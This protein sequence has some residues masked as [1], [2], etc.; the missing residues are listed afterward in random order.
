MHSIDRSPP[1]KVPANWLRRSLKSRED[2]EQFLQP[3][4]L[5]LRALHQ[6]AAYPEIL[7]HGHARKNTIALRDGG[8][9]ERRDPMRRHVGEKGVAKTHASTAEAAKSKDG[10]HQRG[11]AGAVRSQDT[12]DPSGLGGQ[13]DVHQDVGAVIARREFFDL[14]IAVG[15]HHVACPR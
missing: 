14:E 2:I 4:A 13:I 7:Q 3:P 9:A 15:L 1:D 8:D 6:E 11:F 5:P 10:A 12:G